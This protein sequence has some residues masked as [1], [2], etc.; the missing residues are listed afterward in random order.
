[1]RTLV[2]LAVLA[3]VNSAS[4]QTPSLSPS[5]STA[6]SAPRAIVAA[7]FNRDGWID[8]ATAG[9]G[10]DSVGIHL[11]RGAAGGFSFAHDIVVGGGP[12]DMASGDLNRDAIPDLAI[13]NADLH[14]VTILLGIGDGSF[15][16]QIDIPVPGNPRGITLA[17][18]DRDGKLDMFVTR[19]ADGTWTVFYGD[20]SGGTRAE[21]T[22]SAGLHPQGIVTADFNNDGFLDVVIANVASG[23]TAYYSNGPMTWVQSTVAGSRPGNVLVSAD[24]DR[25]GHED[26]A[27]AA[28]AT[29]RVS[30]YRGSASGLQ[31]ANDLTTGSSPRGILVEDVNQ[32]GALDLV[33]ADRGSNT[34]SIFPG[35]PDTPGQ[36]A[37]PIMQPAGSGSRAAAVGDLNHDG[38][39]DLLSANEFGSNTT[40]L[41]NTTVLV[42]AG[43]S[44]HVDRPFGE[45]FSG[46]S[47]D[48]FEIADFDRNGRLDYVIAATIRFDGTTR[49]TTLP[50]SLLDDLKIADFTRDGELDIATL[51]YWDNHIRVWAGD[52]SGNF[53]PLPP[54]T[55]PQGFR[56]EV[57]DL[58]RDGG[59]DLVV[60]RLNGESRPLTILYNRG[61]GTF[62][63]SGE[64]QPPA[65]RPFHF[66][67]VDLDRDGFQDLVTGHTLP[68]GVGVIYGDAAGTWQRSDFFPAGAADGCCS[69][70][71]VDDFNEDGVPDVVLLSE[72]TLFFFAGRASGGLAAATEQPAGPYSFAMTMGDLNRDGHLDV[73]LPASDIMYGRGDGTFELQ[74][75]HYRDE[76]GVQVVTDY[77]RD[78]LPDIAA[79][80]LGIFR[81][82]VNERNATN[83]DPVAHAGPDRTESYAGQFGEETSE[84]DSFRSTDPDQ[85]ELTFEWRNEAGEIISTA[86]GFS[87]RFPSPG[88]YTFTLTAYD[89]RGGSDSD[90]VT[91]TITPYKEVVLHTD[92]TA[93]THGAWQHVEDSTAASG[94]RIFHPDAGAPKVTTPLAA[95]TNYVDISFPADPTQTYKLWIRGK[96]QGDHWANDSVWVQFSGALASDGHTYAIGTTSAL[97]WNLEECSGCGIASWGWEDDAWGAP[98]R[99]GV[100]LRFPNGGYQTIRI[101]TREDGVSLDQI[102]LSAERFLTVRPGTAKNDTV[103]LQRTH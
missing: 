60:F 67:I 8:Y 98:N 59:P 41:L 94:Y 87:P 92:F 101:Q 4:A 97:P 1:M 19:Y 70:L 30:V 53:T 69:P 71:E 48:I 22:L 32:D 13:A 81:V 34:L 47:P 38:R 28:T 54:Q 51:S 10:R 68:V 93:F 66:T 82:M 26:L 52:G 102:V 43:F 2:F 83:R 56:L 14:T 62:A 73:V 86:S 27:V 25:D 80:T 50:I 95:P 33:T 7:D 89:G 39:M 6:A 57:G 91:W 100:T 79:G 64:A 90:T 20:G 36:F 103:I 18:H 12:F 9:T 23:L 35:R 40:V 72:S 24:F 61:D 78:G 77:N 21:T 16:P 44:F 99:N 96:A 84:L 15:G 3:F 49:S 65:G 55:V 46:G 76:G 45:V 88:T 29:N 17:D 85:H 63:T 5:T 31:L 74:R 37:P 42:E 58:N 75:F 11:N